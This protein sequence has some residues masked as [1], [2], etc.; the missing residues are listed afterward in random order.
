M[1]CLGSRFHTHTTSFGNTISLGSTM[2]LKLGVAIVFSVIQIVTLPV[3]LQAQDGDRWQLVQNDNGTIDVT[4]GGKKKTTIHYQGFARPIL[5][6]INN[7]AGQGVTRDWPVVK[8][9]K[10]EADDHPHHKSLWFGHGDVNGASF[11]DEKATIKTNSAEVDEKSNQVV[12][13]SDWLAGEKKI[14]SDTTTISFGSLPAGNGWWIDYNVMVNADQETLRF[15]DTKEGVF[16]IRTHP[17]LR[18]KNDEKRGVTT[19]AGHALNQAGDTDLKLWGKRSPW[20][21]YWGPIG[22]STTTLIMMDH[23]TNLRH[24]TTWHAREYGLVAANPFGLSFFEK[25]PRG[26][27]DFEL[28]KGEQLQMHYR[29]V[30]VDGQADAEAIETMYES[31]QETK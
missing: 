8:G 3:S 14:A 25:K 16:A 18:L 26:A 30:I 19:A 23:P 11:W 2:F 21:A 10:G 12:L 29:V 5:H 24:P 31:F 22:D 9:T 6:P 15:G 7:G 13:K 17:N 4:L 1:D 27:G 28:T 20:V